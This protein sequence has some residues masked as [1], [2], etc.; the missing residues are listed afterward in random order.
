MTVQLI[1]TNRRTPKYRDEKILKGAAA[2]AGLLALG[3]VEGVAGSVNA[4][5]MSALSS[6]SS[7]LPAPALSGIEHIIVVMM[8]NRSFDH[9]LGWLPG[10]DGK[11]AGLTYTNKLGA[12][13]STYQLTDY[14]NCAHPDPDHSQEGGLV[15]LNNGRATAGCAPATTTNLPSAITRRKTCRSTDRRCAN[16]RL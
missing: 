16:A 15:Q 12:A 7:S 2:T 5:S 6:P 14:Q 11:Q 1:P 8:E 13:R 10:A 3:S 9:Y 4:A